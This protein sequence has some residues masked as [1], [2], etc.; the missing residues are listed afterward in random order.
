MRQGVRYSREAQLAAEGA[1]SVLYRWSRRT[2]A[3]LVKAGREWEEET[4]CRS[5]ADGCR[6]MTRSPDP[7]TRAALP[8]CAPAAAS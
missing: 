4:P 8:C 6:S 3:E 2:F 1:M 5:R 7:A